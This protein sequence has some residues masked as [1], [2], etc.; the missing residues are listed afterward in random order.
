MI[1]TD[2]IKKSLSLYK[3]LKS[4]SDLHDQ[5]K[6]LKNDFLAARKPYSDR[7]KRL[8][9]LLMTLSPKLQTVQIT[10]QEVRETLDKFLA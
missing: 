8:Q 1:E 5:V 9:N 6:A 2:Q 3:D 4:D 7:L 10:L